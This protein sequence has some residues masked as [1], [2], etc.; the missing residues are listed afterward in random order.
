MVS[1]DDFLIVLMEWGKWSRGGIPRY[2]C[3]LNLDGTMRAAIN[4]DTAQKIDRILCSARKHLEESRTRSFE[5]YYKSEWSIPDIAGK[6]HKDVRTVR[7]EIYAIE[8]VIY[9]EYIRCP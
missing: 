6:F 5:L 3:V 1:F 9:M 4:D 8:S 7:G 2:R